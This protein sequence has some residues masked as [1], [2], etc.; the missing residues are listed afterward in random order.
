[1]KNVKKKLKGFLER[2]K[3]E[4]GFLGR[5]DGTVRVSGKRHWF[6]VRLWNGEVVE[7]FNNGNVP[8]SFGL[9]VEVVYRGGR[10]Y[11]APRE[12]YEQP[13]FVGLPDGAEDELQWPGLH[14]LY[15]R[16]EQFLPGLVIPKSNLTVIVYGGSLPLANGG[17][18][19]ISTQEIDLTPYRPT[20]N[21]LWA[22]IGWSSTGAIL[23]ATGGAANSLGEL[24][25]DDIPTTGGYDLAAIKMFNG[26]TSISHGKFGSM[27]VDL[28]FFKPSS[29]GG[30]GIPGGDDT[31]IQ[32]N[33]NGSFAGYPTFK[34]LTN[35]AIVI[36]DVTPDLVPDDYVIVQGTTG[37]SSAHFI[38]TFG[39]NVASYITLLRARGT[40]AEPLALAD[41]DVIG[42]IRARG[43]YEG[44][45]TQAVASL[46]FIA[47]SS[48]TSVDN[49]H[50][51]ILMRAT[52]DNEKNRIV[53]KLP[54]YFFGTHVLD[55]VRI[56]NNEYVVIMNYAD[57]G[58]NVT[59]EGSLYIL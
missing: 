31:E 13:V 37:K 57:V 10:Y 38:Q 30:G 27:I 53:A 9:A 43:R 22:T 55:N 56:A 21:A 23:I 40:S 29:S 49:T 33:A 20:S 19:T 18:V 3:R 59:L 17:Y 16:P 11:L 28:R 45:Y 32:V 35:G 50:A 54:G 41:G 1:M 4:L 14:T 52:T 15:V 7:A 46:E 47:T 39:E 42:R 5:A 34:R 12:V 48:W 24:S 26:Q 44:N 58:G 25:A 2:E 36:G 8:A 6:Y 51:A